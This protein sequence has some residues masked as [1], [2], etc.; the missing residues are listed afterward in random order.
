MIFKQEENNVGLIFTIN[1]DKD[2]IK[3]IDAIW[4]FFKN[5]SV[6]DRRTFAE[7]MYG[8]SDNDDSPF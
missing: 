2:D 3:R 1:V 5:L 8:P 4:D 6:K 7:R